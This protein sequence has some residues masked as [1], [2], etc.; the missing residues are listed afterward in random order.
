[1]NILNEIIYRLEFLTLIISSICIF[2]R[3][4]ISKD[5]LEL[6]DII[7]A[8]TL[9]MILYQDNSQP[10]VIIALIW[11]LANYIYKLPSRDYTW[12]ALNGFIVATII[13]IHSV[14]PLHRI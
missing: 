1:M 11:L 2:T 7:I 4:H 6:I 14:N 3:R 5:K 12:I 10:L 9:S 13:S 8:L